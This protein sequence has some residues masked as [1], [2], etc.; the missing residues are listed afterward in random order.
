MDAHN[1]AR[2]WEKKA[3]PMRQKR[4]ISDAGPFWEMNDI[5]RGG[6]FLEPLVNCQTAMGMSQEM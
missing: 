2:L 6:A 4:I 3:F 1:K 5:E